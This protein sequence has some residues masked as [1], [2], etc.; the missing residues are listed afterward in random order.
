[1]PRNAL[2]EALRTYATTAM[3]ISDGMAGDLTKLCRESGV[4]A[5]VTVGKCR[6]PPPPARLAT[7]S[8]P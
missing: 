7:S 1:L 2:I 4:T 8:H 5:D 6:C 3:D